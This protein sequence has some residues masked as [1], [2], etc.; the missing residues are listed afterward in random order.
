MTL[1]RTPVL[2]IAAELDGPDD[3][4]AVL[5]LHGW[6]D[7]ARAWRPIARQLVT[8]GFRTVVP[9]LRGHGDT[10]FRDPYRVRDG[11][12]VA[13]AQDALDLADGLGIDRF[14]VV[15]HDW[16]ARAAY[17]VAAIAPERVIAV[18]ALALPFSPYGRTPVPPFPQARA[19]WYQW[20]LSL[21]VGAEAVR[22]DPIAFARIQWDT[23]SPPGWFEEA[24]FERTSR[25]F[26]HPDWLAVTLSAYRTRTLPDEPVDPA[27][28]AATQTVS[29]TGIL[30]APTL[31]IQGGE[32]RCDEPEGS[33]GL[34][35]WFDGEYRRI[36]LDGVGHF[37]HRE[38]PDAVGD[39]IVRHL[40]RH[41]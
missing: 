40:V 13:L 11:R 32:D 23:W 38:A 7:A 14:A 3:A 26:D 30:T 33:A 24:E 22:A 31:M 37:P 10:S 20:L 19:F 35:R 36:V 17:Q 6:P 5:L 27:Y 2:D 15:G 41:T 4:P 18:T 25:A 28:G 34:D 8:A 29:E 21:D 16:G 39:L 9:D 1:V 12:G